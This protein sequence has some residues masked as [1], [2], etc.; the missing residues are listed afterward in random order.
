MPIDYQ[1]ARETLEAELAAVEQAVLR[2]QAPGCDDPA[3]QVFFDKVFASKTQAYREVLL[4]CILAKLQDP[5]IDVHKPYVAHGELSYNGRTL[6]ERVV[7]P[8]LHDKRIPSSRGPFLSTFRRNVAFVAATRE[9]LRDKDA[10]DALLG[11][12][13]FVDDAAEADLLTTLRY[14]L[15]QFAKL[16]DAAEVPIARLQRISLGQFDQ[17]V[18]GLLATPSGG[19]FPVMLIEAAFSA[20]RDAFGLA[21]DIDVQGINAADRAAGVGGDITIRMGDAILLAAEVTERPVERDRVV[22]TFQTKIAPQG[23][24][25][26]LFFVSD[27]VEDEV[28]RQARQ[29]F[30]QGHEINFLEMRVWLRTVLATVGR[31]GRD[32]F[33]R[34]LVE[35]LQADGV[36][37]ALK[38]AWN[39]QIALLIGG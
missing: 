11:I 20:I 1:A 36:P 35:R 15:L 25:D 4:G 32:A 23:I 8:F 28:V 38:V 37:A 13:D 27:G 16:R 21:W 31:A 12:I 3:V 26:Y 7:N 14:A 5:A 19:R 29:Y 24:E 30:A 34:I 2:R 18:D 33:N 10:Y 9:G 6:D 17:L 22:A 39:E